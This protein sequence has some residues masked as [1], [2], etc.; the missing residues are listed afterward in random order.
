MTTIPIPGIL[1]A[2]NCLL[3]QS[4]S[5]IVASPFTKLRRK[6]RVFKDS[7]SE[8]CEGNNFASL[9]HMWWRGFR[10]CFSYPALLVKL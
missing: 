4:N 5:I 9:I 10:A 3:N 6:L 8:G 7:L 1:V 2:P